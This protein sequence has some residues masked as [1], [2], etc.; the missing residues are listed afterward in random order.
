MRE[1]TLND[2][3][4]L[5]LVEICD[6]AYWWMPLVHLKTLCSLSL[7]IVL[8]IYQLDQVCELCCSELYPLWSFLVCFL[9]VI[10]R[11]LLK[12]SLVTYLCFFFRCLFLLYIFWN[13]VTWY[14]KGLCE[15][16]GVVSSLC[17]NIFIILKCSSL[18][19]VMH[20]S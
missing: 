9:S 10:E 20:L 15:I 1:R 7:Y 6:H 13:S 4:P 2:F 8:Y 16:Q 14:G 18:S 11:G 12:T 19:L 17:F 5:K 3:K